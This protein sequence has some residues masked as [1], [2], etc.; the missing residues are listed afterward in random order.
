MNVTLRNAS[1]IANLLDV[2]QP[3]VAWLSPCYGDADLPVRVKLVSRRAGKRGITGVASTP[4]SEA[5]RG[6]RTPGY[7]VVVHIGELVAYPR[8]RP[9]YRQASGPITI[10]SFAEDLCYVLAHELRHVEQY[11][12]TRNLHAAQNPRARRLLDAD[13]VKA[14]RNHIR[15]HCPRG[16]CEVDAE[17][18]SHAL[19]RAWREAHA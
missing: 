5:R 17:R 15:I 11:V 18:V 12:A 2:A 9:A 14:F 6:S 19:V 3:L 10:N 16:S 4:V 13:F 7:D 8:T 1:R